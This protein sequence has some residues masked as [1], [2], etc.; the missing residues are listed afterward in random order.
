ML[1]AKVATQSAPN[2]IPFKFVLDGSGKINYVDYATSL[3]PFALDLDFRDPATALAARYLGYAAGF[4]ANSTSSSAVSLISAPPVVN[5]TSSI[6]TSH[7]IIQNG[8]LSNA[9]LT[10]SM[11]VVVPYGYN[12]VYNDLAGANATF[13][14]NKDRRSTSTSRFKTVP[15]RN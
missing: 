1:N 3:T 14:K 11:P 4:Q 8:Q 15:G 7:Y 5:I 6:P 13:E 2:P 10:C 12:I 9:P